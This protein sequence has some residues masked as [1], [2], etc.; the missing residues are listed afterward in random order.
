LATSEHLFMSLRGVRTADAR[1]VTSALHY[2]LRTDPRSRQDFFALTGTAAL[3]PT[4]KSSDVQR[5]NLRDR[6]R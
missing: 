6:R 1:T 4:T 2:L 5:S 3:P